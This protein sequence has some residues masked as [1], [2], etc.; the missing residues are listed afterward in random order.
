MDILAVRHHNLRD[1]PSL[2]SWLS[3]AGRT[4]VLLWRAWC[5][6]VVVASGD[7]HRGPL[8]TGSHDFSALFSRVGSGPHSG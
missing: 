4:G 2:V 8:S 3:W 7:Q 6:E 5:G 1:I